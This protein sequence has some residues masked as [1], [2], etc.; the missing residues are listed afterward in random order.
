[1]ICGVSAET[2]LF[3]TSPY[4][5]PF[6]R[7][8]PSYYLK[9]IS[10]TLPQSIFHSTFLCCSIVLKEKSMKFSGYIKIERTYIMQ[11]CISS[12]FEMLVFSFE[13]EILC[14]G[15]TLKILLWNNY[16][17]RQK[18]SCAKV[19]FTRQKRLYRWHLLSFICLLITLCLLLPWWH[20]TAPLKPPP[21]K[22]TKTAEAGKKKKNS[23][24][25]LVLKGENQKEKIPC[26]LFLLTPS[27]RKHRNPPNDIH[28][29]ISA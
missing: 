25:F 27:F 12:S 19:F 4:I 13:H 26:E 3:S 14:N 23:I 28:A 24:S 15:R 5:D 29:Q 6:T 21:A 22:D 10:A 8:S 1:M 17:S 7:S 9:S 18:K 20:P 11:N 2:S 16:Y